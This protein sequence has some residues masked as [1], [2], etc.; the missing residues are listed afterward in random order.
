[1]LDH[2]QRTHYMANPQSNG[3]FVVDTSRKRSAWEHDLS[4]FALDFAV[5][6]VMIVERRQYLS[7]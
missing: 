1:M 2:V 7:S 4:P 3:L 6:S 5:Q